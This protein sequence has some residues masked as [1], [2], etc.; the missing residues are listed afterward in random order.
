MRWIDVFR[1]VF[2]R[3]SVCFSLFL[4]FYR[5]F[6]YEGV[7]VGNWLFEQLL[8]VACTDFGL[9]YLMRFKSRWWYNV[10]L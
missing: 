1:F 7:A 2:L 4:F 6:F 9:L 8:V 10:V 3:F 5:M